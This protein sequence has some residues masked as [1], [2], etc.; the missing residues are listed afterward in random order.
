[1]LSLCPR[2]MLSLSFLIIQGCGFKEDAL[3]CEGRQ[4]IER[5]SK[6]TLQTERQVESRTFGVYLIG[7]QILVDETSFNKIFELEFVIRG[8]NPDAEFSLQKDIGL[9]RL[10]TRVSYDE[11]TVRSDFEGKCYRPRRLS[12]SL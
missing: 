5:E 10:K 1:M 8:V 11:E 7:D 3:L 12:L 9:L 2:V 4:V 6:R